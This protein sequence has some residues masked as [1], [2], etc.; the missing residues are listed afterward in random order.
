MENSGIEI[1][2]LA[3]ASS[4]TPEK[5]YELVFISTDRRTPA[6]QATTIGYNQVGGPNASD[7]IGNANGPVFRME[8]V[9][10]PASSY[11]R[12][13][14]IDNAD[15]DVIVYPT[16]YLINNPKL[17]IW[18]RKFEWTNSAGV[19][20]SAPGSYTILGHRKRIQAYV[21]G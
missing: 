2:N 5:S 4:S 17:D 21:H 12:V 14:A 9:D 8:F 18:L 16:D 20:A 6:G 11:I 13:W 3:H 15:S 19:T 1:L 10:V 7:K